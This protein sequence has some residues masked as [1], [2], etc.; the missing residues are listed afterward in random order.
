MLVA[1]FNRRLQ[2]EERS[3]LGVGGKEEADGVGL[4]GQKWLTEY[5]KQEGN[6]NNKNSSRTECSSEV[7]TTSQLQ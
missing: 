6:S 4:R 1:S 3:W 7:N 2:W 5:N